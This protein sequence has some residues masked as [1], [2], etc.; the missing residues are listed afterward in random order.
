M[1]AA[2]S[3][4]ARGCQCESVRTGPKPPRSGRLDSHAD[5]PLAVYVARVTLTD[6]YPWTLGSA[7]A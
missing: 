7:A 4:A 6:S 3:G 2:V 5:D 1:V